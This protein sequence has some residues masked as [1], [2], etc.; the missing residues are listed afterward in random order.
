M[1]SIDAQ[2][3]RDAYAGRLWPDHQARVFARTESLFPTRRVAAAAVAQPLSAGEPLGDFRF[4]SR[5]MEL[6]LFDHFSRNR[7]AGMLVLH[8]GRVRFEHYQLGAAADT[9]W[10]SMSMAKSVSSTLVG[11]AMMHWWTICRCSPAAPTRT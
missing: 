2:L 11:A 10:M 5:G 7:I 4:R 3:V 9:R 8:R 1:S 6:D